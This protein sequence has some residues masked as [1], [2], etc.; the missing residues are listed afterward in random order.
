MTSRCLP[1]EPVELPPGEAS[2]LACNLDQH[3]DASHDGCGCPCGWSA[4]ARRSAIV[5]TVRSDGPYRPGGW[6]VCHGM[7]L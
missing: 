2:C 1:V 4:A 6:W 5:A 7:P 3:P